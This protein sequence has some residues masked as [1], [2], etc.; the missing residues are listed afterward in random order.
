MVKAILLPPQQ[1]SAQ[2]QPNTDR[3]CVIK[4]MG[5]TIAIGR[6]R[7]GQNSLLKISRLKICT[8][9]FLRG[10]P[11]QKARPNAQREKIRSGRKKQ[12]VPSPKGVQMRCMCLAC[13]SLR[14]FQRL[15][16]GAFGLSATFAL[17]RGLERKRAG[18]YFYTCQTLPPPPHNS[19]FLP[20]PTHPPVQK[21][22]LRQHLK[23][24]HSN[25]LRSGPRHSFAPTSKL[26]PTFLC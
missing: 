5:T 25:F 8:Q 26:A 21:I 3:R 11:E 19:H 20:H 10:F 4:M 16:G 6:I 22:F 12:S 23:Q 18:L 7:G 2:R 15:L 13:S 14:L 24:L 17:S 9:F 1:H